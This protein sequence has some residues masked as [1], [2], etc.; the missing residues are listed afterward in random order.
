MSEKQKSATTK[1]LTIAFSICI[2][3]S[4]TASTILLPTT[5]AHDPAWE[6]PTFAYI[7][8]AP[9]PVG[10]D[11]TA[12]IV[13]WMDKLIDGTLMTNNIRFHNYQ[14]VITDP[15]GETETI[16]WETVTDTTSSAYTQWTPTKVGVYQLNFTFPGQ[17]YTDYE[18]SQTSSYINDTYLP[19]TASVN[20]TVQEEAVTGG[21]SAPLPTEYWTRPIYGLNT[22]WY[23]VSSNW[24]GT[25]SPQLNTRYVA[26]GVGPSTSHVMWTKELQYGG[27]VGGDEYEIDGVTYY[28]GMSYNQR[29]SNPIIM[30]GTLYYQEPKG[31]SGSG[32]D[33][34]AVDLLTGE[35]QWRI[36]ASATGISLVPSF[37]LLY[38]YETG[39]QHGVLPNGALIATQTSGGVTNW[40]AYDPENGQLT[41]MNWTGV[42]SGTKV[43]GPNGEIL[44]YTLT[45]YGN[46]SNPNWYL[47]QWNS[48]KVLSTSSSGYAT[49]TASAW[50]SGTTN[51]STAISY[52]W[53]VSVSFLT[54]GSNSIVYGVYDD[55]LLGRSGSLSSFSTQTQYTMWG[56]DITQDSS[57]FGSKLWMKTYDPID[58][59]MTLVQGPV[60]AD[61]RV[62]AMGYK[63]VMQWVGYD[64][65]TGELIWGPTDSQTAFDYYGNIMFA[66]PTGTAAYGNLYSSAY[67]GIL[68]C[69]DM[70][71]GDLEWTYGNGGEGNST[72][73]GTN[74]VWGRYPIF[75]GAIADDKV[76]LFTTEHSPNSPLAKDVLVRCVNAT[77]G[78][79]IWTLSGYSGGS[80]Y[81]SQLALADG[82]LT[83]LN[84]YD[85]Q[86][87]SVGKGPS[88]TTVTAPN[89]GIELGKSLVISGSVID[90]SAGT[91]QDEQARKFANGV[92]VSSDESMTDWMAYVYQQ[93]SM[94][95]DFTGVDVTIS[96]IDANNN[97]R[98]IGTAATDASGYYS[99]N[100]TPDIEGKYTVI[101]TFSGTN[102]YY[103]SYAESS[104]VVDPASAT[105]S[106]YPE[107][108][109]PSTEM[110]FVAST[111]AIIIAVAI[112]GLL[113][114]KKRP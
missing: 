76:Y 84:H 83:F 19:S 31:N 9:N 69:Y 39:N 51:V 25:G 13:V 36:N 96:V 99:L 56:I 27:V 77:D 8:V 114:L 68:Y 94:P 35:E 21:S 12:T 1:K 23:V 100:W 15:D 6:I 55:I 101:A 85:M 65:D 30:Q 17:D 79:E 105:P 74:N 29:F 37:G 89:A 75:P 3:L 47:S 111:L 58:D 66:S 102:G 88:S 98:E 11:Q 14:V 93:Q 80:T 87:Y 40:I 57:Q 38:D 113:I 90:V 107:V 16:D 20:V 28:D 92:P 60:D 95:T 59:N 32:G 42:P 7:N 4:M 10:V 106:P 44:I 112:V 5:S 22:D 52:D 67:G 43:M 70:T 73:A 41:G 18:Y 64:L 71:T 2:I 33:Y 53:N 86:I 104:F 48:S 108:T 45:N 49:A 26:D 91:E 46:T 110:Y 54:S 82:Y 34:V 72:N 97:Y 103:G 78:S 63:E 61:S 109:V 62:F 24:L 50:Y 81:P